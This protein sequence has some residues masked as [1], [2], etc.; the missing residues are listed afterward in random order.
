MA[1]EPNKITVDKTSTQVTPESVPV[2]NAKKTVSFVGR[3]TSRDRNE[4]GRPRGRGGRPERA[5]SEF[6]Q[7]MVS[8][9]RVTRVV[10]GGRR[11]SFSVTMV[12]GNR[13]G[14]VGVGM[15]KAGDTTLAIDKA[16]KHAKKHMLT[17]P[18]TKGNSLPREVAAK[19]ASSSVYIKPA[20][21][22]GLSAGGSVRT[23][24]DLAGVTDVNAKILSRSKNRFNNARAAMLALSKI[25]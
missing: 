16:V 5:K 24:L 25:K 7:S 17:I 22:K 1:D 12:V 15:G 21:G 6:A 19:Y 14:K 11:F 9:R 18:R 2:K 10:A 23:V 8:I 4:H 20:P 13:M 3:E